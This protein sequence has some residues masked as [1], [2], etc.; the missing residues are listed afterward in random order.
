MGEIVKAK[1]IYAGTLS[2]HFRP[3]ETL[4]DMLRYDR[5]DLIDEVQATTGEWRFVVAIGVPKPTFERWRTFMVEDLRR[6]PKD[7]AVDASRPKR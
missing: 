1:K 6:V 2:R 7:G 5:A 4:G 3:S